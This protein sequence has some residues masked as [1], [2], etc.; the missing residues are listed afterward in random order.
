MG[1]HNLSI[2]GVNYLII[3]LSKFILGREPREKR[4]WCETQKNQKI[5]QRV[6]WDGRIGFQTREGHLVGDKLIYVGQ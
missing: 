1:I 6:N 5:K 2:G 4:V 3:Q